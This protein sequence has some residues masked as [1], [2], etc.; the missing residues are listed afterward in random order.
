MS[1]SAEEFVV[2]EVVEVYCAIKGTSYVHAHF[3]IDVNHGN[4]LLMITHMFPNLPIS[5]MTHTC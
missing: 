3:F 5:F 1:E 4:H 2:P